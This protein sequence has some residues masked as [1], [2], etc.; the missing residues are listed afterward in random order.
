MASSKAAHVA[1]ERAQLYFMYPGLLSQSSSVYCSQS[2]PKSWQTSSSP[3]S[4]SSESSES[5][6]KQDERGEKI[7]GIPSLRG[8]SHRRRRRR[9]KR[10]V[11]QCRLPTRGLRAHTPTRPSAPSESSSG[12][13]GRGKPQTVASLTALSPSPISTQ[14]MILGRLWFERTRILWVGGEAG[15]DLGSSFCLIWSS[16]SSRDYRT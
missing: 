15:R 12:L 1:H 16:Y 9:R 10:T 7:S 2:S 8:D 11:R 5:S 13:A 3:E 4:K 6:A 14:T